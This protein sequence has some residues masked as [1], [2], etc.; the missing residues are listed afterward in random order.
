M[1]KIPIN[2]FVFCTSRSGGPGGQNVN[3]VNTK[4]ELRFRIADSKGLSEEEKSLL[5]KKLGKRINALGELVLAS[6]S[7][8]TQLRNKQKVIEKFFHI[9]S[10]AL[11]EKPQRK[12][13]SPTLRSK[14]ERLDTKHFRGNIKN[15][16][17]DVS[18]TEDE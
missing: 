15:L 17:R 16:R 18:R 2:E 11:Y 8:R 4:V 1:D 5:L 9:I 7:E 3:K 12:A 13:T 14:E 6:Q 10:K